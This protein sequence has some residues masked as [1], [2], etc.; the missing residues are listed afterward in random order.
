MAFLA[1]VPALLAED[2]AAE[3]CRPALMKDISSTMSTD[4]QHYSYI[5]QIDEKTFQQ[6][7]TDAGASLSIPILDD[8]VKASASYSQFVEKRREYFQRIGYT[9]DSNRETRDVQI[10]TSPLAYTSWSQCVLAFAADKRTVV[11]Y[12]DQEDNATVHVVLK[13]GAPVP[14]KLYSDLVNGRVTDQTPGKAFK[15]GTLLRPGG[16]L[17]VLVQREGSDPLKLSINTNPQFAGLLVD[18]QWGSPPSNSYTGSLKMTFQA[19]HEEDRGQKRGDTWQT[20]ELGN[21][22]CGHDPCTNDHGHW[23]LAYGT[24][25]VTAGSGRRLRNPHVVCDVDNQ[26]SCG[27][28]NEA[29]NARCIVEEG[30]GRASCTVTTGSR[31]HRIVILANEYEI[32]LNPAPS[33]EQPFVMFRGSQFSLRVPTNAKSEV[34]EYRNPEGSGSLRPGDQY[35]S[36]GRIVLLGHVDQPDAFY[37]T[38]RLN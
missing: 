29:A 3:T 36:D 12:K 1:T 34:F 16:T 37:Y 2:T 17:A 31:S 30:G 35:S 18:S 14:V 32:V 27:W 23:Q 9:N 13:N 11:I 5:S 28:A 8:L 10:V 19:S 26:G 33:T 25:W 4:Q 21:Q 22:H 7:K 38:Y 24:L 6:L 15:D 20:P